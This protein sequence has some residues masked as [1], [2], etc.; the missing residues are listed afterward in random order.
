M[1]STDG[2]DTAVKKITTSETRTTTSHPT[3]K[4]SAETVN[5]GKES[6]FHGRDQGSVVDGGRRHCSE[7]L[8]GEFLL[9]R[10]MEEHMAVTEIGLS[11]RNLG[12][13]S[14]QTTDDALRIL[15]HKVYC[16]FAKPRLLVAA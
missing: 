8:D 7:K 11:E 3:T 16:R 13:R 9:A 14:R 1:A 10:R 15:H 12:F 2:K 5:S 4:S 6:T